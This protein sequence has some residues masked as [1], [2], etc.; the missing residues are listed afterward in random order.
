MTNE[1]YQRRIADQD[2][3]IER[4]EN[5]VRRLTDRMDHSHPDTHEPM[6]RP[7]GLVGYP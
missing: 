4:L 5:Q 1:E 6:L 2:L 3:R 7:A